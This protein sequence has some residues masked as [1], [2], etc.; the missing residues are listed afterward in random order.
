MYVQGKRN[1]VVGF[2]TYRESQELMECVGAF[3]SG[4]DEESNAEQR[5]KHVY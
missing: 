3:N 1:A 4:E 5:D 2:G